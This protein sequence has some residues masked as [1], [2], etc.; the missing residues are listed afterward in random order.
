MTY[1]GVRNIVR[2]LLFV[3]LLL[4]LTM[5]GIRATYDFNLIWKGDN[6]VV[7]KASP[8]GYDYLL[9]IPRGY[10]D[11]S[12]PQP[13]LIFLHGAGETG[14]DPFALRDKAPARFSASAFKGRET[15]YFPFIMVSPIC[16]EKRWEPK[17]VMAVL[18][19]VLAESRFRFKI[20]P[21]RIYLTGYSMGGFG[22]V[23][24][25]ME[26][27]EHFAAI[28]PV[29][30]GGEPDKAGKLQNVSCWFFHGANDEIVP[31]PSSQLLVDAMRKNGHFDVAINVVPNAGHGIVR[32]VY[33]DE[34]IYRW[35]LTKRK[36]EYP[37][38]EA[39][40]GKKNSPK[41]TKNVSTISVSSVVENQSLDNGPRRDAGDLVERGAT[42]EN[43]AEPVVPEQVHAE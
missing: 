39:A 42:A 10:N 19:Q 1:P 36:T 6:I 30:G 16:P 18:D 3:I 15:S 40:G 38:T 9:Q 35:I 37:T 26:F 8:D 11:F 31:L 23:E 14:T 41:T 5:I 43:L 29:A 7:K 4:S 2:F 32:Q 34:K 33:C 12:G 17:R 21:T 20:D 22:T 25:A 13:L 27:P 28:I 24:T